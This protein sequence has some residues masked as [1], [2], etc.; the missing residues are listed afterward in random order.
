VALSIL[1]E[2]ERAMKQRK[3]LAITSLV[4]SPLVMLGVG[5]MIPTPSLV[6]GL[7]L[8]QNPVAHLI[9]IVWMAFLVW[10]YFFG[11]IALT[12]SL[13]QLILPF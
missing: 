9:G 13:V 1:P 12:I 5:L 11:Y 3:L 2:E 7:I 4:L 8:S 10:V 6:L